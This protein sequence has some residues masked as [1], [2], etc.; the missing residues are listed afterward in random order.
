MSLIRLGIALATALCL[1][2]PAHAQEPTKI[3]FTLDWKYQG[4]HA[5]IFWA[6][7]K[8]YFAKEGLDVSIDQGTGSSATVTRIVSG[9]Y[10]AGFGDMNAIIQL[11]GTKPGQ[12]PVMVYMIYNTPPFALIVKK[13]SPI[14]TLKDLEGRKMGTPAGGAAGQLF[15]ALAALNGIDA[16]KVSTVNMAPNLQE[17]MLVKDDVD[18]SA[19]FTVTSY[20]NLIGMKMDPLK[21]FR[22]FYYSDYGVDLYSNGIMVS[23]ALVTE[24]P[25]AVAGL[26]RALNKAMIEVAADPAAGVK[27]MLKVEPLMD[28]NIETQRLV[29]ALKT[30][31]VSKETDANGLGDVSDAR[32]EK[33]IKLLADTYKLPNTPAVKD[34]FDRSFLPPKA[35]RALKLSF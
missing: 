17:Q 8:G 4:L 3:R 10:D 31:F 28:Q 1:S 20:A 22:W 32:M 11:A 24:K 19:I 7:D 30:H 5:Y 23:K 21:D 12:Q 18:F 2:V 33:A 9:T 13:D 34:V 15:P 35:E 16:S 27:E 6:K 29:Y 25:K 14:K 26:V